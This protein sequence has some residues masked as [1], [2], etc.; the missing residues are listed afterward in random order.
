MDSIV[1]NLFKNAKFAQID[2]L[3]AMVKVFCSVHNANLHISLYR[4]HVVKYVPMINLEILQPIHV[5]R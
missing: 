3:H 5:S 2:V 4:T 1:I